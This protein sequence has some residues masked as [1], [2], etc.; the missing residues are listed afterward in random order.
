[1]IV[2]PRRVGTFL[3]SRLLI[4]RMLSAVE[5]NSS[6][7]SF[8]RSRRAMMCLCRNVIVSPP[9]GYQSVPDQ[10]HRVRSAVRIEFDQYI[11]LPRG[12]HI[13][14]DEVGTN[15]QFAMPPIDQHRQ[16]DAL[17]TAEVHQSIHRR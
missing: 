4:W 15:R 1:M 7:S 6:M 10:P 14:T 13:A 8:D 9:V 11:F 5:S 12:R 16:L 3:I 17:R 2:L